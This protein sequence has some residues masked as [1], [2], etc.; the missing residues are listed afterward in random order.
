[1]TDITIRGSGPGFATAIALCDLGEVATGGG[2]VSSDGFI[3]QSYPT[4]VSPP[5]SIPIGWIASAHKMDGTDAS[6][7]AWVVCVLP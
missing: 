5:E 2:G 3:Y 1:V 4:P 7:T 6:V